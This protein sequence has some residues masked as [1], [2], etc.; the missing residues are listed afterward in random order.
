M[1]Q[2]LTKFGYP[3]PFPFCEKCGR[4]VDRFEIETPVRRAPN[5]QTGYMQAEHTGE[6][7][8]TIT[9]HGETWKASNWHGR[10]P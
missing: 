4:Q 6:V 2:D 7:I 8:L 1:T 10:L 3:D 9:C 5:I